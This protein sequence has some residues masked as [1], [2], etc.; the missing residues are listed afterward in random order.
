MKYLLGIDIGTSGTKTGLFDFSGNMIASDTFDY[1]L[2]HPK[3]GWAEQSPN[4]WWNAVLNGIKSVIY[5]SQI[6][7]KEICSIGLSGQMHGIVLLDKNKCLLRDSIIWCDQ[8]T[9]LECD[10]IIR[11]V[12]RE[13]LINITANAP[14]PAF[15][16]AK[17]LWVRNNEPQI[18]ENI[19]HILLPKD[20]IR[21]KL[22]GE[23][24]TDVSDASGM[25]LMDVKNRCWSKDI[26]S[27]LNIDYSFLPKLYE[28]QEVTGCISNETAELTGLSTETIVVGG[29]GDNAAAAVGCG[30]NDE[31]KAMNT[32]GSSAVVYAI[33]N[34][35]KI[36]LQGRIHAFC[37]ALPDKWTVMSCTQAAGLS[38]KWLRDNFCFESQI[39]AEDKKIDPYVVM[40]NFAA[41]V[42]IGSDKLIYLPYLMGE[43]SPH[44]DSS[45][46][47]VFFGM[48]AK[49]KN[50]NFI[51][52]VLEGVAFSQ[53]E[54]IDVFDEM[55]IPVDDIV[56]CAGGSK[57]PLWRQIFAD[58]YNCNISILQNNEGA[59]LGAALLAGVG[60]G[61][62]SSV[63]EASNA[64][65]SISRTITPIAQNNALYKPYYKLY[66]NLY[67]SLRDDFH[68]LA[69]I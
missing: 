6:N 36:D 68:H 34:K 64:V 25:Q 66:K 54:C 1:Q 4:D 57:S 21:F 49:H 44:P 8:R 52:A 45:C 5:S 17:I 32:I 42:P 7:P 15:S 62:Y 48:S 9:D 46:R 65:I 39:I 12:G 33:S 63:N 10:E 59:S 22:T 53:K 47:G 11:V 67:R 20:F 3:N 56:L 28:S 58:V 60:A 38:L 43:R 24:A 40:D 19:A 23:M 55:D 16:A 27:L 31:G 29:A 37:A 2:H 69:N 51:R 13:K 18:Y 50:E 26:I 35:P 61:V 14:M 30:V 41:N